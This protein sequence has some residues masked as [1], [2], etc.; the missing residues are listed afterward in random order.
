MKQQLLM[1][2]LVLPFARRIGTF[3]A[4]SVA[5]YDLAQDQ[6]MHVETAIAALVLMAADLGLSAYNRNKN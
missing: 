1:Q 2:H 6:L 4:G 5:S 3:V